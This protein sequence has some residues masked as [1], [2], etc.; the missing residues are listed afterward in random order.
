M[1][2]R[3]TVIFIQL[4]NFIALENFTYLLWKN[5]NRYFIQFSTVHLLTPVETDLFAFANKLKS[6]IASGL[7]Q[8]SRNQTPALPNI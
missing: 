5:V 4:C 8:I 6:L 1:Y 3:K 2:F 7:T